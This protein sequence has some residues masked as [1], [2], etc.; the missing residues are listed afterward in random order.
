[1]CFLIDHY[2]FTGDTLF[3]EGCGECKD[4][5]ANPDDLYHSLQKLK[6]QIDQDT[7][8]FPGHSFGIPIGRFFS[9][10]N[11]KNIYLQLESKELFIKYRFRKIK[12]GSYQY[13]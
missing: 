12:L 11:K 2:L 3:A 7:R 9:E 4:K 13:T 6:N 5:G 10:V 1:M 8:I